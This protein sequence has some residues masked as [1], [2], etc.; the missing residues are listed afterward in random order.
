MS[1]ITSKTIEFVNKMD[2]SGS[3]HSAASSNACKIS[4]LWNWYTINSCFLARSWHVRTRGQFA[5]SCIGCFFLVMSAQWLHRVAREYD[6]AIARRKQLRNVNQ[7][8]GTKEEAGEDSSSSSSASANLA[9]QLENNRNASMFLP[10]NTFASNLFQPIIY[11]LSHDWFLNF[12]SRKTTTS[13]MAYP[14]LIEH[15]IRA[16]IFT[17]QWGQSYI[18]MLLFMYYNGYIIISCILGA[19]F[20]RLVFNYEPITCVTRYESEANDKKCCM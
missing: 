13:T 14:D 3:A 2:M 11:A 17:V 5:G 10:E 20:G 4:M 19:F 6:A 16:L 7:V 15:L 1:D 9:A 18:I 12:Q 8:S